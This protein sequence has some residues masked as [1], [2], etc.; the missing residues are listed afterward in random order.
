MRWR[1]IKNLSNAAALAVVVPC[2]LATGAGPVAAQGADPALSSLVRELNALLDRGEQERLIDPWFL[3]DL[4]TALTQYD[5]PW[6]EILLSDDFSARGPQP[7]PPWQVTSGEFLID[8]RHGL[9]SVVEAQ[10]PAA[11]QQPSQRS[12]NKDVAQALLGALL[13]GALS[14]GQQGSGST[15][16]QQ[17]AAAAPS[18]AAVQAPVAISNA[19]LIEAELSLRALQRG[20]DDGF[21]IGPYQGANAASGY[22]L[23]YIS[24]D[25]AAGRAGTFQLLRV[26]P[27]GGV[28]TLEFSSQPVSLLDGAPHTLTWSRDRDGGMVISVDGVAV[29]TVTDRGFRDPF[30][31]VAV[32]N[33]GGDVA[34]RRITVSGVPR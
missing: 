31:G 28:A 11:A 27:R 26:S 14:N 21:E 6:T 19:F 24:S 17:P 4:R 3:R 22:R 12:D 16:N 18:F 32:V 7:D 8:W 25:G 10:A 30:D 33:R 34:L 29:I 1:P 23:S 5:R 20:G 15:Q 9:R 2:F 13:Q